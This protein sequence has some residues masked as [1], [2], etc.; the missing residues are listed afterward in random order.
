M[1]SNSYVYIRVHSSII[2]SSQKVEGGRA[3]P[4]AE[5]HGEQQVCASLE[6]EDG[7]KPA[8]QWVNLGNVMPREGASVSQ[9]R[10]ILIVS[11]TRGLEKSQ[12]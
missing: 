6:S 7:L 2:H 4:L 12:S 5:M 8:A 10:P 3:C 1:D 9:K 11:Y